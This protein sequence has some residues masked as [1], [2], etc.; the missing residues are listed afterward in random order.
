VAEPLKLL[1]SPAYIEELAVAVH[2]QAGSFDA[3]A[4]TRAVLGGGWKSLELKQRMRRISGTLAEYVPGT[5]RGQLKTLKRLAPRFDGFR[6]LFFPDFVEVHGLDDFDASMDALEHFTRFSSSEFAVRPF[7]VRYGQRTMVVMRRWADDENEHV[8]RLASEGCR[9]RLPWG[10]ALA[11]FKR[12]PSP[13]LPI[14]ERLRAD[15][16]EYVRRSVA[17]NLNDIVKDHPDL[18][19]ETAKRWLGES[20]ET[21]RLVKHAC[22]TLLKR[23]DQ[24]ALKLFG[25]HDSVEVAVTAFSLSPKSVEIGT[26]LRFGFALRALSATPA[27]IEYAI[28]FVNS[29]GGTTRKVFK[30]AEKPLEANTPLRIE[31]THRFTNF[32]TRTHYP[33]RHRIA[34]LVN[35]VERAMKRFD[36][37]APR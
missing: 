26:S 37:V 12:D 3:A 24:R 4:F 18:V 30:V 15:P 33:G 25:H 17:N 27:R 11:Q 6:G 23:G 19:L 14:L 2:E 13:V 10:I 9:P 16:S 8:R 29:R 21:D 31:R 7:I 5:Y 22:R 34:V 20:P 35:G 32:T 28:D 36:V 1:Y